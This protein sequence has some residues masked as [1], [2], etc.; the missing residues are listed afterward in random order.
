[1]FKRIY[2][3]LLII[4]LGLFLSTTSAFAFSTSLLFDE[5]ALG[6][7]SEIDNFRLRTLTN[8]VTITQE[9]GA[10]GFLGNG[11]RFT[12]SWQSD[13]DFSTLTGGGNLFHGNDLVID[14]FLE[15]Y[16]DDF[17]GPGNISATN[18]GA[19]AAATFD[20]IF[21]GGSATISSSAGV[22]AQLD[23]ITGIGD[24]ATFLSGVNASFND[25]GALFAFTSIDPNAFALPPLPGSPLTDLVNSG[26]LLSIATG[27]ARFNSVTGDDG[28]TPG[29]NT[30]DKL[31]ILVDDQ[32]SLVTFA[33]V[34]EPTTM[35]LFGVGLIGLA[36]IGRRRS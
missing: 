32:G 31:T 13:I 5:D 16:V 9:L 19:L 30:D 23:L 34:P 6:N 1:M 35:L 4:S 3:F 2:S 21:D 7:F 36:G 10:D 17:S 12:E 28:G 8:P 20:I 18:P 33:V 11:D 24:D 15:G 14:I 27:S 25:F 29:D 26:F 22:L